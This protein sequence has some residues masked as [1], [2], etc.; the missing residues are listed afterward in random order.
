MN[1]MLAIGMAREG[2][3]MAV[4]TTREGRLVEEGVFPSTML[5]VGSFRIV[6]ADREEPFRL[7]VT[8]AEVGIVSG[9]ADG[10]DRQSVVMAT[11]TAS[12]ASGVAT[13]AVNA[14]C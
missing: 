1:A 2:D 11:A 13:F 10:R 7:A 4:A 9:R 6:P 14:S 12:R 8:G 5:G 3:S